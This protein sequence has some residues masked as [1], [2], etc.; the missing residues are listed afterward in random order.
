MQVRNVLL[1]LPPYGGQLSAF[2]RY[3]RMGPL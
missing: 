1:A 3:G 2:G